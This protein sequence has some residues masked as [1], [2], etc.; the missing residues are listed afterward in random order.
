MCQRPP[1]SLHQAPDSATAVSAPC[2]GFSKPDLKSRHSL[3]VPRA[4]ERLRITPSPY[5][6]DILVDQLA[7][8]LVDVW[9]WLVLP[10]TSESRLRETG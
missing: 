10:L 5:H 6:D 9:H 2:T 7:A 3:A 4:T 8:A 1:K